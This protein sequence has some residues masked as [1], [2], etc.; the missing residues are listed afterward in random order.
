MRTNSAVFLPFFGIALLDAARG[1]QWW[2][3][4]FWIAIGA[5]FLWADRRQADTQVR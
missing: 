5:I 4:L 1:G 2:R 3:V